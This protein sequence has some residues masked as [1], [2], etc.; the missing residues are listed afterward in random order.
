MAIP[1]VLQSPL[2]GNGFAVG[3]DVVGFQFPG[4]PVPTLDFSLIS[5]LVETGAFGFACS[6]ACLFSPSSPPRTN[7]CR[8]SIVVPKSRPPICAALVGFLTYRLVLSQVDNHFTFF[9]L[10]AALL[11]LM[12]VLRDPEAREMSL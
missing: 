6:S 4:P 5:V 7:L 8:T 12:V 11:T 3:A 9:A 2:I 1:H 10:V